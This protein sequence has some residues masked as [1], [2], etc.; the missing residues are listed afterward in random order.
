MSFSSASRRRAGIGTPSR[1][2]FSTTLSPSAALYEAFTTHG[3]TTGSV[4]ARLG[5]PGL[6]SDGD[7][8]ANRLEVVRGT[9][10]F[11]ASSAPPVVTIAPLGGSPPAFAIAYVDAAPS[12]AGFGYVLGC[13]LS[14][15]T[16]IAAGPYGARPTVPLDLDFL[17]MTSLTAGPPTFVNFGGVLTSGWAAGMLTLPPGTPPGITVYLAGASFAQGG[18]CVASSNAATLTTP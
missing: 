10:P 3:D 15:T 7:G 13:A 12:H 2:R 18:A 6:D 16:G 5:P 4:F 11:S 17:L 1:P 8:S 9:D 14:A